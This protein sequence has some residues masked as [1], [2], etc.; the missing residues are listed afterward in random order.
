MNSLFNYNYR[1]D[2]DTCKFDD[3]IWFFGCS[4]IYGY[5]LL[6]DQ[7]AP[8]FLEN[9]INIPVINLGISGGNVFNIKNN[10]SVLLESYTPKAIILAWP[11]PTR[12]TD[13][14]GFNWGNWFLPEMIDSEPSNKDIVLNL[15]RLEEY[16][17][18]LFSGELSNMTNDA[19]QDVREMCKDLPS[20]EFVLTSPKLPPLIKT[21]E[22]Q[23]IDFLSDRVHPGPKTN[24]K[25]AQWIAEQLKSLN[26]IEHNKS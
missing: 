1:F 4:N 9:L 3:A 11:R 13:P 2:K 6:K 23:M 14:D 19:I 20:I 8:A 17:K 26:V 10:L 16:K 18:L 22:I 25:V 7:T 24:M 12:W 5:Q 15:E 21:N